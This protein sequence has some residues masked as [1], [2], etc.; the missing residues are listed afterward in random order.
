M[1]S[2]TTKFATCTNCVRFMKTQELKPEN[3]DKVGS[4][5]LKMKG[6]EQSVIRKKNSATI[7][8]KPPTHHN[9]RMGT[10]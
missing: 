1:A 2:L 9:L 4:V 3:Q 10:V 7:R 8:T 6:T 5:P